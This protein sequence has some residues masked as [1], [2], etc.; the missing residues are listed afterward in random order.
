MAT[1]EQMEALDDALSSTL[2]RTIDF[3]KFAET[4][5][6]ALL[7]FASGMAGGPVQSARQ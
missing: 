2:S 1:N 7:T 5:N 6:A 4:K 3:L